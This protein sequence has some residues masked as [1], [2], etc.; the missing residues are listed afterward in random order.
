[1]RYSKPFF[2][3]LVVTC[4]FPLKAVA[5]DAA[6]MARKMQNPLASIKAIM[7]DN[8]I[9]F[10]TGSDDGTSYGFQIQPVYAIDLEEG[11]FT[12]IPRAV[13]PVSGT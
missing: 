10:D 9:G 4:V 11:G 8:T 12:F 7:T 6:E 2:L 3:I 1:M 5:E 13:L